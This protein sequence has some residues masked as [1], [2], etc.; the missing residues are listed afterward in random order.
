MKAKELM[1]NDWV[2]FAGDDEYTN[3]VKIDAISRDEAG[4]GGDWFDEWLPVPVTDEILKANG[5]HD[6][7]GCWLSDDC[8]YGIDNQRG[9][10]EFFK[11]K[12]YEEDSELSATI[13]NCH[14]VHE[15]QHAFRMCGLGELADNFI[16]TKVEKA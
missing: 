16:I 8:S 12:M 6:E 2:C 10:M 1:I 11:Y 15:L 4:V 14:N 9:L 7:D 5:F 3:P 13:P